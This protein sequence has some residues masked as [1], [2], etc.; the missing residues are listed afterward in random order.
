MWLRKVIIEYRLSIR[1]KE[2]NQT[3]EGKIEI[4]QKL[5]QIISREKEKKEHT[6]TKTHI[7]K[8]THKWNE[9]PV[10]MPYDRFK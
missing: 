1:P 8:H 2:K 9:N 10:N 6:H 3:L 5:G 4:A 7:H